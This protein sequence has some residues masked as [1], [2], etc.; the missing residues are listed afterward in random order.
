MKKEATLG[1][2]IIIYLLVAN[3]VYRIDKF[4][5]ILSVLEVVL[6]R[7]RNMIENHFEK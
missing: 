2:E 6:N 3:K 7:K 4:M 5:K 1:I